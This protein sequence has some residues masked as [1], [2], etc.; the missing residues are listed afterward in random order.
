MCTYTQDKHND[1]IV[2]GVLGEGKQSPLGAP[3]HQLEGLGERCKLPQR[4]PG[5]SPGD[6]QIFRIFGVPR[7]A[8]LRN[9]RPLSMREAP[10][11]GGAGGPSSGSEFWLYLVP[12]SRYRRTKQENSLFSLP[13]LWLTPPLR[14]TCQNCWIKLTPEQ[15]EGLGYSE[16]KVA[17]S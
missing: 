13:H 4:G 10:R 6:Q 1:N 9:M 8:L 2:S 7:T 14:G 5:R 12:F 11:P 15:L 16:V 17:W 3:P